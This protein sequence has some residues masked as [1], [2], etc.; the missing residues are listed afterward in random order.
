[1]SD[2]ADGEV[3]YQP[4]ALAKRAE[5]QQYFNNPIKPQY[6]EPLARCAPAGVPKSFTWH[7]YE[8]RQYPSYIVFIFGSG[9]RVI[10]LD[11][12]PHLPENIKLWN[13]DSRGHWE[14]QHARR[15]RGEQQ[16][17]GAVR[18]LRRFRERERAHR[19]A[20]HLR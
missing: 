19:R 13:A 15:R 9:T 11:G 17:E 14:E 10:H 4:W 8:I 6:I 12:K 5:F 18:P 1:M 20:L 7:G 2:P 16:L 3:P